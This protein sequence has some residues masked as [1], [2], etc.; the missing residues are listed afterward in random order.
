MPEN[1][2]YQTSWVEKGEEML[3]VLLVTSIVSFLC[4]AVA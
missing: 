1:E 4:D 2:Q 3:H